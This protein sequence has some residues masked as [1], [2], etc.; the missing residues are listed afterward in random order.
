MAYRILI[1]TD[2][3][4]DANILTDVLGS[5]RDGPFEVEWVRYLATALK[6][7][8]MGGID[9]VLVDLVLP[10]SKG[11]DTFDLLFS[12]SPH[13][14]IMTLGTVEDEG[15]AVE[16]VQRGAQG[17]LAKGYF[18]SSLVP[19]TIRNI[20]QR[21]TVEQS[22]YKEKARA[23]IALNSIGDAV[24]CTDMQGNIDYLNIAAETITGWDR[25]DAF[26]HPIGDVFK[27]V[28]GVTRE[29]VRNTVEL[30]LQKNEVIGLAVETL[31]IR[32]DGS[33]TLIEDSAASIND[34]D[35]QAC[36]V[37]IVFHDISVAHAM[38]KKMTHLAQHDFLTNLPN[39][40]LLKDRIEQAISLANRN[41]AQLAILFLDLDNFKHIN[42][43]L[44][45]AAGDLLLQSVTRRL[46]DCVRASDTVS[47]QG[48]DEFVI[49]LSESGCEE[50]VVSTA[51]KILSTLT[52]GHHV[53]DE[54]LHVTTSIGI[55]VYPADGEDAETLIKNADT[56]MYYAKEKGRNNY[57][58]F[59]NEMN[60]R[61]VERQLIE[62]N[63]R[64]AIEKNE[65]ILHYQPKVNLD[66]DK[67]T[68][69]EALLRWMHPEWGMVLPERFMAT[70]EDCGLIVPIGR[71]VL[72]EAC[73]QAQR[74]IAAGLAPVS[75]A[76]NISAV[77]FR[78]MHF[79]EGVR[80]ILHETGLD[81]R[82]LELEITESVLMHDAQASAIIL[83]DLKDMGVH[84]AV[85]DFGTG[86]SSLSYL[87]QFPI[88][89][90]KIDQSFVR[91]IFANTDNGI[92]VG[93]V[94]SMGNSLKLRVIA[95]G[96]ENQKQ[97]SFLK[98]LNCEEGQG[99]FFSR[100][101]TADQFSQLLTIGNCQIV[102]I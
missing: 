11:I 86:Y 47:R 67:V 59:R 31:L 80:S 37:V 69:A 17:Y 7:L 102:G 77:E 94:I 89:V 56:A 73:F 71:W 43:S 42:D 101:L 88:D 55:S 74:W 30:V 81:G 48:G 58:F 98:T 24:I 46:I 52:L 5:A 51:N 10:D 3:P 66:N 15:L 100:P 49:L 9:A 60:I 38:T 41:G 13:T 35:G 84:I 40:V 21:K 68:G 82:H 18:A 4:V 34:W 83:Q 36:G 92:I 32:R 72:R 91:G 53:G 20:I 95:E 93:A 22:F 90:L 25:E 64:S 96:I 75:V 76:V 2:H 87:E 62:A 79:L 99:N 65:F 45:H 61:A 85:D 23:E 12:A 8:S 1:V 39:R 63:L 6:R 78:H 16:A 26:G 54:K 57:Q 29:P 70:A 19:Q 33:E 28:S 14:P 50:N 44:G 97:L 27:I